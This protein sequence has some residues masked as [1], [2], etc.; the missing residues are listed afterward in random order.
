MINFLVF[1]PYLGFPYSC[2]LVEN[3]QNP[4]YYLQLKFSVNLY[5][6]VGGVTLRLCIME[7]QLD[8]SPFFK[9]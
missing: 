9:K 1:S 6:R 2:A 8:L 7:T 4:C 5:L 3:Q